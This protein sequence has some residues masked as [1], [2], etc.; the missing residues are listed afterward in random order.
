[1][2][3]I[4]MVFSNQQRVFLLSLALTACG[5]PLGTN[6]S[7]DRVPNGIN[8]SNCSMDG[9]GTGTTKASA[10]AKIYDSNGTFILRLESVSA[11]DEVGLQVQVK[12]SG[13]QNALAATLKSTTGNQNYTIT[14][15]GPFA[16]VVIYSTAAQTAY[17]ECSLIPVP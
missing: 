17:G 8:I 14:S 5:I 7:N 11:P 12:T 13:S 10:F 9:P 4:L 6:T 3:L 2:L 1:M 15:S 16:T